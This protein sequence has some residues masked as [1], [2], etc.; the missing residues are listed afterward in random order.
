MAQYIQ[1]MEPKKNPTFADESSP[2]VKDFKEASTHHSL[3][4]KSRSSKSKYLSFA[5]QRKKDLAICN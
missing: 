2:E 3:Y 4:K 1:V 5:T